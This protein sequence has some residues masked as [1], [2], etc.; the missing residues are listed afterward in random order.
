MLC[1]ARAG[2]MMTVGTHLS[3]SSLTST[4][5]PSVSLLYLTNI[6]VSFLKIS[7]LMPSTYQK[8]LCNFMAIFSTVFLSLQCG[9]PWE[10][11]TL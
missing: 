2:L 9:Q 6:H 1:L 3:V 11:G 7:K 10:Q 4:I 5:S 8:F